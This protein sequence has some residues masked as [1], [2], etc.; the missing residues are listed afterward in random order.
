MFKQNLELS[1]LLG[2]TR[3]PKRIVKKYKKYL[4]IYFI[5]T[6]SSSLSLSP[7]LSHPFFINFHCLS[8]SLLPPLH[9]NPS[10]P[11]CNTHINSNDA[12]ENLRS[13]CAIFLVDKEKN[14]GSAGLKQYFNPSV[15]EYLATQI[16]HFS[17]SFPPG[18]GD[19]AELPH[20]VPPVFHHLSV[21]GRNQFTWGK[22]NTCLSSFDRLGWWRRMCSPFLPKYFLQTAKCK[23]EHVVW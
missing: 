11:S 9:A 18:L 21:F 19:P 23:E 22:G 10:P 15:P 13:F 12:I 5:T 16:C 17:L 6:T 14:V 4:F 8:F 1:S 20:F 3:F 2:G 7:S